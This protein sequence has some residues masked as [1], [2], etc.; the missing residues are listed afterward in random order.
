MCGVFTSSAYPQ[1]TVVESLHGWSHET[2]AI[3][4]WD[5]MN[6]CDGSWCQR[7]TLA[8]HALHKAAGGLGWRLGLEAPLVEAWS[9]HA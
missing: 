8:T 2:F 4:T 6:G 5:A 7:G 9:M 3:Y 1:L